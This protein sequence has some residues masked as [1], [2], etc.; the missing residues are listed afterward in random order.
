MNPTAQRFRNILQPVIVPV[1]D[2][3]F[4]FKL[5]KQVQ[6]GK[7]VFAVVSCKLWHDAGR[8][9]EWLE[10]T[11]GGSWLIPTIDVAG[12]KWTL[13]P[14]LDDSGAWNWLLFRLSDK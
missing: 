9:C 7:R 10:A 4:D 3:Y 2:D 12:D 5:V 11:Q 1:P 14:R 6:K 8:V 13:N